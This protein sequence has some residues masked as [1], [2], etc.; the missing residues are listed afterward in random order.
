M[1]SKTREK[2][3]L[4]SKNRELVLLNIY[5]RVFLLINV[6]NKT[7]SEI[8]VSSA[9]IEV[10]ILALALFQISNLITITEKCVCYQPRPYDF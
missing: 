4:I 7:T 10:C 8:N 1:E 6:G 3:G 2:C 9:L 5:I